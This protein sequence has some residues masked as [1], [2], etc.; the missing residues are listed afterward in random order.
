MICLN[1]L[2]SGGVYEHVV[3][4]SYIMNIINLL[5]VLCLK[6]YIYFL[7][8]SV[9]SS[10]AF[11]LNS[12]RYKYDMIPSPLFKRCGASNEDPYHIFFVCPA[13]SVPR[14]SFTQDLNRILSADILQ[15][16]KS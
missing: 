13:Y 9:S 11:N 16:K 10:L 4:T 1:V 3:Y 2:Q 8:N 14:Q 15:N 5:L 6:N 7:H 12:Q